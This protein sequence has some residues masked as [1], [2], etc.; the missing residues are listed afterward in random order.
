MEQP[1]GPWGWLKL[2]KY[3]LMGKIT[4]FWEIDS[5]WNTNRDVI[6]ILFLF[7]SLIFICLSCLQSYHLK[8]KNLQRKQ[9]TYF[10]LESF[11]TNL[12]A[13]GGMCCAALTQSGRT[14]RLHRLYPSR[15]L[16]PWG[17]SR[18]EYWG[19]LPCPS[20]GDLPTQR[21]NPGLPHFR[22]ILYHLSHRK[23]QEYWSG[24]PIPSPADLPHSGIEL[25]SP[26]LQAD[27]LP[28]ELP[29]K[30]WRSVVL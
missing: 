3:N 26:A 15:L 21:S 22:Q 30:P 6:N 14:L 7:N 18:Q 23:A 11:F 27:S 5:K 25:G 12:P 1:Q 8:L 28:A 4:F 20:P 2:E 24:S 19:G 29:G 9:I 10:L 13:L 17:F 16:C